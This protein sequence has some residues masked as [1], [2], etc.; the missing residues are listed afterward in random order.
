MIK[1]ALLSC[2]AATTAASTYQHRIAIASDTGMNIAFNTLGN[3]MLEGT[4]KVFYG[5]SPDNLTSQ[6]NGTSS[7]YTTSR[8]TTHKVPVRNLL[9]DTQ[10]YYQTCLLLNDSCSRSPIYS[11]KTAVSAGDQR[12]FKFAALGD[13]GVMGP[14]GGSSSV[15]REVA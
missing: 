13:M 8:S 10:Y 1:G 7:S 15:I 9:S 12:E 3:A 4:P 11:F 5:L 6:A 2:L 14:L